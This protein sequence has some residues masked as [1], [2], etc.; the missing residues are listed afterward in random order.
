MNL[1]KFLLAESKEVPVRE[2]TDWTLLSVTSN[3]KTEEE[4]ILIEISDSD[5]SFNTTGARMS[6]MANEI[7]STLVS[8]GKQSRIDLKVP[9]I[10]T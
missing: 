6:K 10:I 5:E 2:P 9:A 1:L 7:R 8:K 4:P 3:F